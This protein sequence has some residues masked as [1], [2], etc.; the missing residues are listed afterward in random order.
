MKKQQLEKSAEFYLK[1]LKF[2]DKEKDNYWYVKEYGDVGQEFYNDKNY[3]RA[4]KIFVDAYGFTSNRE[5]LLQAAW[6]HLNLD[7]ISIAIQ[8]CKE[9][10]ND[11]AALS[12]IALT[13]S[14]YFNDRE[15]AK[16]TFEQ[17]KIFEREFERENQYKP[18]ISF[19]NSEHEILWKHFLSI[20]EINDQIIKG[21]EVLNRDGPIQAI[22]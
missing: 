18:S 22:V 9:V 8:K 3:E 10:P 20:A 13:N 5:Y 7:Q 17:I 21:D 6:C 12:T 14:F 19:V 15:E 1:A 11:L 4:L 2:L 16:K